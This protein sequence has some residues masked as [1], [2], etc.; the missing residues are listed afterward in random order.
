LLLY[1]QER[2]NDAIIPLEYTFDRFPENELVSRRLVL[3]T[4]K[5]TAWAMLWQNMSN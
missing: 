1:D 5:L 2:Y 3:L 4:R